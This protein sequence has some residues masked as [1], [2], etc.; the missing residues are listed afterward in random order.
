[1]KTIQSLEMKNICKSFGEVRAN[2]NINLSVKAG[3]ILGLLG[4]NGA[5]KTTL[6]NI[7]FGLYEPDTGEILVDGKIETIRS[8]R[9]SMGLGIG[10]VHQH[11]M[12]IDNHTVAENVALGFEGL[13]FFHPLVDITKRLETFSRE[14][15]L[16]VDPEKK[17]WQLSAGEQ[18]RVEIVKTLL[19]GAG[20][21]ILDEPTSVLTP[22]EAVELFN[23]LRKMRD[24]G[25]SVIIISHKL[26][27]ILA[28][29][30][31]VTV[32][33][34]GETVGEARVSETRKED[35]ASMMIGRT[36]TVSLDKKPLPPG[37]EVLNLKAVHAQGDHGEEAVKG[38]SF[39]IRRNEIFGIAGVSGNGQKEL[40]E[41]I[42][43]L[44]KSTRGQ[45]L[46]EGADITNRGARFISSAGITHVPE[47]RLRFAIAP[48]L[49]VYDNAVLKRHHR[50]PF[51]NIMMMNYTQVRSHAEKL[52][53]DFDVSTPSLNI[54][55]KNLSGGNIQ[56]LILGREIT[57]QHSLLV[58]SHPTYGLDVGA[59]AYVR[60]QLLALREKG[61]A[62]LLVSEDLD[63]IFHLCDRIAVIFSGE[64]MGIV[65][66]ALVEI[67]DV[68]MMMAGSLR[69][70]EQGVR[71]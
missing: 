63:E 34:R 28:I 54:P 33:R 26:E 68:G 69:I 55:M 46:V 47:E 14:F 1:M 65:D 3:E 6:M 36:M 50:K 21:L 53:K 51:S 49:F 70:D 40:V 62:V 39:R 42:T 23:I 48:G 12:L 2:W 31:R 27:E 43:G 30:D 16:E 35:L 13:P 5:G 20:L 22:Q 10:M 24:Q 37:E 41:V 25:R 8:P 59:T 61:G 7:L 60:E 71:K 9:D 58:A 52:V 57:G 4:E 11:Y 56:K 15:G 38:I 17:I 29:C 18:Q 64:I 19:K 32:L 45:I 66:P 67:E 44:R